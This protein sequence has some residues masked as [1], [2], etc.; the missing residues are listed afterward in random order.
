VVDDRNDQDY[1]AA[2]EFINDSPAEVV[3]LQHEFGIYGGAE[4][5]GLYRFLGALRKPL[6]TILHTVLPQPDRTTRDMIRA[7]A[8]KSGRV[9]VMN[10]IA[11]QIL[12]RDY[13]LPRS[14]LRPPWRFLSS[15]RARRSSS[16]VGE[17]GDV[18]LR[19]GGA[20]KGR[21]APGALAVS[22]G[23]LISSTIVGGHPGAPPRRHR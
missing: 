11:S 14:R 22:A 18:H 2:A 10:P 12:H 21:S 7:L 5:R 3:S 17:E 1:Q 8:E 15:E 23:T 9:M 16:G 13:D 6:V 20:G 4:G 19:V